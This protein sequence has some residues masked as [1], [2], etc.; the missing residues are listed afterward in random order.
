M[1]V[2]D[3]IPRSQSLTS[4]LEKPR[5]RA[6][7][8]SNHAMLTRYVSEARKHPLLSHAAL[9]ERS[10]AVYVDHY[11]RICCISQLPAIVDAVV[12]LNRRRQQGQIR[13]TSFVGSV[14]DQSPAAKDAVLE[15]Y[16]DASTEV[17]MRGYA[18]TSV[19]DND[20]DVEQCLDDLQL[21][22]ES[23]LSLPL[24]Q[25][26]YSY[27]NALDATAAC[28]RRLDLRW[29]TL[30][31]LFDQF[32][33]ITNE[34]ASAKRAV[35]AAALGDTPDSPAVAAL[36]DRVLLTREDPTEQ[37]QA[38]IGGDVDAPELACRIAAP[39]ASLR[40]LETRH[41]RL[42]ELV[43]ELRRHYDRADE[44]IRHNVNDI[45]VR[46]L[47]LVLKQV[48]RHR[49]RDEDVWDALQEGND[50]LA[51]AARRFRYWSGTRFSTYAVFWINQRLHR[52]RTNTQSMF[53]IPVSVVIESVTIQQTRER[54]RRENCGRAPSAREIAA[55]MGV[56]IG[57]IEHVDAAYRP[58]LG[59][60]AL[61][62]LISDE[63]GEV[64]ADIVRKDLEGVI[65]KALA[66]VPQREA[67]VLRMHYGID[68]PP[69]T[70]REIGDHLGMSPERAR[71]LERTC[72]ERLLRG[73]FAREL[74]LFLA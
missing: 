18:D 28:F 48:H 6:S 39:L 54:L 57:R 46:N 68:H 67:D 74:S 4:V 36:A 15:R 72:I 7:G 69:I 11:Q 5:H 20:D 34:F 35:L 8:P 1:H 33:E 73:P 43:L 16:Q 26:L 10:R 52:L 13:W 50:G 14:G 31:P 51:E 45:V 71:R 55:A 24:E 58:H 21:L 40:A 60:E 25:R 59:G 2:L 9:V 62:S 22:Q 12:H 19:S 61:A 53:A 63:D 37:L 44:A 66:T 29:D 3:A 64:D 23:F 65:R 32:I 56:D 49:I 42:C 30:S 41:S 27:G 38:L 17:P 47:L 70:L